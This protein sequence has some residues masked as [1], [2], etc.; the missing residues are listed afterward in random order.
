MRNKVRK[1]GK[2]EFELG[3]IFSFFSSSFYYLLDTWLIFQSGPRLVDFLGGHK[4]R[5]NNSQFPWISQTAINLNFQSAN[6]FP[7]NKKSL[8]FFKEKS[9]FFN[10]L[11]QEVYLFMSV[12]DG[13]ALTWLGSKWKYSRVFKLINVYFMPWRVE[14]A[15]LAIVWIF[16]SGGGKLAGKN[17]NFL[18][19]DCRLFGCKPMD[20]KPKSKAKL[21]DS[22]DDQFREFQ[23]IKSSIIKTYKPIKIFVI[24]PNKFPRIPL[25]NNPKHIRQKKT[26]KQKEKLKCTMWVILF[27]F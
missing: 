17:L 18:L 26:K 19:M 16:L 24:S 20:Q 15:W 5:Q 8:P 3:K 11:D 10:K 14:N 2:L 22:K 27:E 13:F 12:R 4:I 21:K 9:Y 6:I 23:S 1:D 25:I 7:I